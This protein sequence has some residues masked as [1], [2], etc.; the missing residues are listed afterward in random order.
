M[1]RTLFFLAF[2]VLCSCAPSP[3]FE[4]E[5]TSNNLTVKVTTIGFKANFRDGYSKIPA[6]ATITNTG[7]EPQDY[8]NQWLW[9]R[10]G[11]IVQERAY[12]DSLGSN[13]IDVDVVEIEA[14]ETLNL[15][16][17]WA[18]PNDDFERLGDDPFVLEI[19]PANE[20]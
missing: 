3:K 10:S 17:Y 14:G 2:V 15:K 16:I 7:S 6:T 4:F 11:E 8:S 19:R 13:A 20:S 18:I 5:T 9:L 1:N 12:L